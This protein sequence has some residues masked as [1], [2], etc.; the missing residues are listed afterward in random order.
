MEKCHLSLFCFDATICLLDIYC[1]IFWR[2]KDHNISSGGKHFFVATKSLVELLKRNFSMFS[3][4]YSIKEIWPIWLIFTCLHI[5]RKSFCLQKSS[6]I[7]RLHQSAR[8]VWKRCKACAE[9]STAIRRR[10]VHHFICESNSNEFMQINIYRQCMK[11]LNV[12]AY[13]N[14]CKQTFFLVFKIDLPTSLR[15][16]SL[17]VSNVKSILKTRKKV[18]L[19]SFLKLLYTCPFN[20]FMHCW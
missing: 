13:M 6:A 3:Q 18:C 4:R 7:T 14:E 2:Q 9:L 10:S 16:F 5:N 17:F 1:P 12:S 15:V 11:K 20:F 8:P 19:H